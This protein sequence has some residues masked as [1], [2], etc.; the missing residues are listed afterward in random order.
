MSIQQQINLPTCGHSNPFNT[1][2]VNNRMI[3]LP[4]AIRSSRNMSTTDQSTNTLTQQSVH[5]ATCQQQITANMLT[6]QSVQH[7][8]CQQADKS[9]HHATCH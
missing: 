7:T 9:V 1:Q 5:H 4:T 2:H 3:N 6:Q 8:R